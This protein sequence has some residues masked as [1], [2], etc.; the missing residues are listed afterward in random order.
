MNSTAAVRGNSSPNASLRPTSSSPVAAGATNEEPYTSPS[1]VVYTTAQRALR[2]IVV[3]LGQEGVLPSE[4]ADMLLSMIREKDAKILAIYTKFQTTHD[5]GELIQSLMR[6]SLS[7]MEEQ[8]ESHKHAL[9]ELN[10]QVSHR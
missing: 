1:G 4:A 6:L 8:L 3:Q 9:N 7:Q 2:G 5:A 10:Q